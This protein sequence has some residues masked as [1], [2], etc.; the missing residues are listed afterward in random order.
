MTT[1]YSIFGL[2]A[3][4][5]FGYGTEQV[6][7]IFMVIGVV[8]A[9]AQGALIGPLTKKWGDAAVIKGALVASAAG[10]LAMLP[11]T[12]YP[13]VLLTTG[14][15]I[16]A[17]ALLMPA[18]MS[19]TSKHATIAQGAAMGLSNSFQSLGRIA[20]PVW[21]GVVFDINYD[22]PYISGS[23]IMFIGFLIALVKVSQEPQE[24]PS[25]VLEP[26]PSK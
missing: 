3:L 12:T 21:G 26:T 7:A 13:T 19:L 5:K 15:F 23:V 24:A 10:F 4:Q 18:V 6:G 22:Y 14:L 11:A 17:N 2:Y 25:N 20:G 1:F 16:L 8:S 9:A